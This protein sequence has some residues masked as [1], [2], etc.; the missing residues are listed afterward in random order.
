M[1]KSIGFLAGAAAIALAFSGAA[2]A[3]QKAPE[4][5]KQ[6]VKKVTEQEKK[7]RKKRTSTAPSPK[8]AK[9]VKMVVKGNS[10]STSPLSC[11]C[12]TWYAGLSCRT[13]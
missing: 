5:K 4:A 2:I 10:A 7:E 6:V 9:T 13:S 8:K 11:I 1:R 12:A 3:Q